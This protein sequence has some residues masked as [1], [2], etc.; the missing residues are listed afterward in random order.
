MDA[1]VH[2]KVPLGNATLTF[3][4]GQFAQTWG[5]T[6]FFGNNGIAGAMAPIDIIKLVSVPNS[7]FEEIIRPVPQVS[8]MVQLTDKISVGAYYQLHWEADRLPS[9]GSY[10]SNSDIVGAGEERFHLGFQLPGTWLYHRPDV[11]T[12]NWGQFGV[13][14][15]VRAPRGWDL[16]F[17]GAQYNDKAMQIYVAPQGASY[18]GPWA[19]DPAYYNPAIGE[20]GS[21]G[22]V[23]HQGIKTFGMSATKTIG[24]VNWAAEVSGRMDQDLYG[25]Q[26]V[27]FAPPVAWGKSVSTAAYPLGS[28]V[29]ANLNASSPRISSPR[30][31]HCWLKSRGTICSR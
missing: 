18:A 19:L 24:V 31:R 30:N 12:K 11:P 14:V 13:E 4:A 3:R 5:Q 15:L 1:F 2:G 22:N 17:Y 10:F 16:G 20:F 27:F 21:F 6:L 25:G 23:F 9:S 7:R 29:H 28:T 8:A 26:T